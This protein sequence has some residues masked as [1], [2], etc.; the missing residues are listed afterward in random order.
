[1][2]HTALIVYRIWNVQSKLSSHR[3]KTHTD[4][5]ASRVM[6]VLVESGLLYTASILVLFG[7]YLSS[8]NAILGVSDTVRSLSSHLQF[9]N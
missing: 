1:M 7:T 4:D 3:S 9:V 2:Q 6:R 5:P 8:N